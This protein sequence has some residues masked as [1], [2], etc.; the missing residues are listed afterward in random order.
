MP[1]AGGTTVEL[2]VMLRNY[3]A[4]SGFNYTY[5]KI[6]SNLDSIPAFFRHYYENPEEALRLYFNWE[7]KKTSNASQAHVVEP[8][9]KPGHKSV[10]GMFG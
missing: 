8:T 1:L 5:Y 9:L 2:R 10:V 3:N 4:G 6:I 7:D